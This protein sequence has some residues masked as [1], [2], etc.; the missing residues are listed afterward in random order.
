MR[1]RVSND[2]AAERPRP[3]DGTG[4]AATRSHHATLPAKDRGGSGLANLAARVQAVGGRFTTS[5]AA[6]R[7]DL[8][9]E[10]PPSGPAAASPAT[11]PP[12]T[13]R[14]GRPAGSR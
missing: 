1:L 8:I 4:P 12:A 2:G 11:P 3:S 10:I 13:P 5:H 9:A 7:F 14:P 6:G